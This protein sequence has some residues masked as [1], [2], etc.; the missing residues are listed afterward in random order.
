MKVVTEYQCNLEYHQLKRMRALEMGTKVLL[1][2]E[3][4]AIPDQPEG[5]FDNKN[6]TYD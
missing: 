4:L 5:S 6:K 2:G 3:S 1:P